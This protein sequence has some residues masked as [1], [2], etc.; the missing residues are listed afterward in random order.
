MRVDIDNP[1]QFGN[2]K[3]R[4]YLEPSFYLESSA[5]KEK[6]TQRL[7]EVIVFGKVCYKKYLDDGSVVA[8]HYMILEELRDFLNTDD[9]DKIFDGLKLND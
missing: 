8:T 5:V 4:H 1:I 9:F 6:G 2:N 7:F 3:D